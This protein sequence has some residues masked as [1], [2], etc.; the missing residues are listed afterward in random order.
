MNRFVL[1]PE[2][3]ADLTEIWEYIAA[4]NIVAADRVMEEI[5]S[6]IQALI[7]FPYQGHG[8]PDLTSK[9]LRFVSVRNYL[10]VYAPDEKPLS[11]I[12]VLHGRRNPRVVAAVL[13]GRW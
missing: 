3:S 1:H 12:A 4:E 10:I 11:V 7:S 8:R 9:P 5:Y 13:H 2:A 6:T